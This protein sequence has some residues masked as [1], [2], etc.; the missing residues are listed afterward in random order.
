MDDDPVGSSPCV[1]TRWAMHLAFAH[2]HETGR[3]AVLKNQDFRF[4]SFPRVRESSN[5]L[6]K[7]IPAFAGMTGK[8]RS[9]KVL[10]I[11][12]RRLAVKPPAG[13]VARTRARFRGNGHLAP[14]SR[15]SREPH[16][17]IPVACCLTT[18]RRAAN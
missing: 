18:H 17:R 8:D 1:M 4:S 7:W 16:C 12:P 3:P 5:V 13:R 6:N 10:K 11:S 15:G 2:R 9:A 14:L